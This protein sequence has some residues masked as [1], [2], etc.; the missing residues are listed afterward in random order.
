MILTQV[1]VVIAS[2]HLSRLN[3]PNYRQ[4]EVRRVVG[5]NDLLLSGGNQLAYKEEQKLKVRG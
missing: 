4:Q 2:L 1:T 3:L 5:L